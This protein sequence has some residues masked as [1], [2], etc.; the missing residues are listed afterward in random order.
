MCALYFPLS[1]PA[2]AWEFWDL[3]LLSTITKSFQ[4]I[5]IIYILSSENIAFSWQEV[6]DH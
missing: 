2:D 6:I 5:Y 1:S 4:P 3:C